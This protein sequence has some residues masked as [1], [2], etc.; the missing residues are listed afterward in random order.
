MAPKV[1]YH[2]K[3]SIGRSWQC[4]TMQVD[5]SMPGRH[6]GGIRGRG[7]YPQGIPGHA[8]PGRRGSLERFIW[9]AHRKLRRRPPRVAFAG[10]K[11]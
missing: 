5:F 2:L 10:G 1:E 8:P 4:G 7:Q 11:W 6:R 3:D 9:H